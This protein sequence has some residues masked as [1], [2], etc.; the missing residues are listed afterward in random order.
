MPGKQPTNVR[1][2]VFAERLGERIEIVAGDMGGKR[3]LARAANLIESQVH[4][5]ISAKN[6]PGLN[7]VVSI[8]DAAGISL[9][10]LAT[11]RGEKVIKEKEYLPANEF[12]DYVLLPI[13]G[14]GGE[15]IETTDRIAVHRLWI[16]KYLHSRAEHLYLYS[17]DSEN[18]EPTLD[19]G[20]IVV[21]DSE[22]TATDKDGIYVMKFGD[23][24]VVRRVQIMPDGIRISCDSMK[25][26]EVFTVTIDQLSGNG[27]IQIVG[28]MVSAHKKIPAEMQ[29]DHSPL[30]IKNQPF[31]TSSLFGG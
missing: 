22:R 7:V 20:D 4:K 27:N 13:Y 17:V 12:A 3:A 24:L 19:I 26:R 11:G 1:D 15:S 9:E 5:Y 23:V 30:A 6:M 16:S 14:D 28:R 21:F 25:Y 29:W 8:A 10:W 2:S 31:D 18:M